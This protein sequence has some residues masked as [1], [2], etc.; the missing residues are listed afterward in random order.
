LLLALALGQTL[1]D[2]GDRVV[3]QVAV[4]QHLPEPARDC[5]LKPLGG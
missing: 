1:M 5:L 4:V 3:D 2:L